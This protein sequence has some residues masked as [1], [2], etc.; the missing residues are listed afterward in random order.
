MTK[1]AYQAIVDT[2][3][4][5]IDAIGLDNGRKILI[6]YNKTG[7]FG[8]TRPDDIPKGIELKDI[9]IVT[10]GDTDFLEVTKKYKSQGMAECESITLHPLDNIQCIII[11][12]AKHKTDPILMG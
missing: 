2:Y 7:W 10:F 11:G 12:D 9:K 3:G 8:N 4:D 5:R 6:G 1:E